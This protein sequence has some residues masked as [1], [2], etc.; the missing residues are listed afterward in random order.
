MRNLEF[1]HISSAGFGGVDKDAASNADRR[2]IRSLVMKDFRRKQR[3]GRTSKFVTDGT[4]AGLESDEQVTATDGS[5]PSSIESTSLQ[6][7]PT[8][9]ARLVWRHS[10]GSR[11]AEAWFPAGHRDSALRNIAYTYDMLNSGPIVSIQDSLTLLHAGSA[12]R[13]DH[14]LLEARK[15]Y[16]LVITLLRREVSKRTPEVPVVQLGFLAMACLMCEVIQFFLMGDDINC[17]LICMLIHV[18]RN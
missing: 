8:V 6:L 18:G 10:F 14:L 4:S 17:R 16:V 1:V 5:T 2:R 7:P 11:M 9:S 3:Q 13:T 15:R 12:A